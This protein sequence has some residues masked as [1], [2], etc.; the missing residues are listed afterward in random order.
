[1]KNLRAIT[2]LFLGLVLVSCSSD[3]D[4]GGTAPLSGDY[5]PS[6]M[7]DL[8][9]YNVTNRNVDDPAFDF[10]ATDL[11][12]VNSSTASG[13]TV[14]ANSGASPATGSMNSFLV[15]GTLS[16]TDD[17]LLF[18]GDLELPGAFSGFSDE[19]ITLTNVALYDLNAENGE[20][21]NTPGT[22][23]Q[24][25]D[26][27]GS[28]FPLTINYSFT[29]S[30]LTT[31]STLTVDGT[32]YSDVIKGN[33]SLEVSVTA[34]IDILGTVTNVDVLNSQDILTIDYYFSKDVGLIKADAVQGYDV[35]DTF[36]QIL[37]SFGI[38]LDI[39]TTISITNNQD[40]DSFIISE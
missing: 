36:V 27:N 37:Q 26:I 16:K 6:T 3:D 23:S 18:T 40:I 5:F 28:I 22:I 9:I 20:L 33:L 10:D 15:G 30:K 34:A 4:G 8:W 1:M 35:A 39:P 7:A 13:Y 29:T 12:T 38:P 19:T 11:L 32:E 2:L 14:E 17:M 25:L 21:S 24:D 31:A